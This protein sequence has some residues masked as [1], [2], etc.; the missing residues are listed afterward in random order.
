MPNFHRDY[1]K[2][3]Y[4]SRFPDKSLVFLWGWVV[5]MLVGRVLYG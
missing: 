4:G 3:P 5:G 2:D 1:D